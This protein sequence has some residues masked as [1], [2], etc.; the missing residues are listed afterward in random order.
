MLNV[1]VGH[2]FCVTL[3]RL[4]LLFFLIYKIINLREREM[5]CKQERGEGQREKKKQAPHWAQCG[6]WSGDVGVEGVDVRPQDHDL[7]QRQT[8]NGLD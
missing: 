8:V 3:G 7:S 1:G 2:L 5:E 4:L 6:G